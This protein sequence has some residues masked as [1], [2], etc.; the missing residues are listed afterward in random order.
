MHAKDNLQLVSFD[1]FQLGAY[2][3]WIIPLQSV[4]TPTSVQ[5]AAFQ[6][7]K[8]SCA[9]NKYIWFKLWVRISYKTNIIY[10]TSA[11][12]DITVNGA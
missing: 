2:F 8:L 7:E 6:N 1:F 12:E 11:V 5:L 10:V 9:E 4:V 3:L